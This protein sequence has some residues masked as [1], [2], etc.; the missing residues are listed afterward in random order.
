[1]SKVTF[2]SLVVQNL[3]PFRDRQTMPLSVKGSKPVVLV[4][5]L[6]GSG[7][8][9]LLTCLQVVLYGS[10]ALG[11]IRGSEYEQLIRGL[12]RNDAIG[13][14][15]I[16]LELSVETNGEREIL[17]VT[18]EWSIKRE[19]LQEQLS[20]SRSGQVDFQLT[21]DW[22]DYLDEILPAE[23]L[24]LFLFD[25]EKIEALA[26]PKTLPD[27]LRRATEAFLG[28]GGIDALA[29]NLNAVERRSLLQ[30]RSSSGDY[31]S[32]KAELQTLESGLEEATDKSVI[33]KQS[34]AHAT[35]LLEIARQAYAR[36]AAEAQ[37]SGLAAYEKAAEVRA[38]EHAARKRVGEAEQAV[39][40]AL[41]DPHLPFASLGGLWGSYKALWVSE[42]E[43]HSGHQLYEAIARRDARLLKSIADLIPQTSLNIVSE[44]LASD[45]A[46]IKAS[47]SRPLVLVEAPQ[48]EAI[49][50][51]IEAAKTRYE[52]AQQT[53][54]AA[55]QELEAMER[56]V[57]AIPRGEQLADML[58]EM[59]DKAAVV[60]KA[61]AELESVQQQLAET[62]SSVQHLEARVSASKA[63]MTKEFQGQA[64]DSRA[65]A[66]GQRSREILAL[67]KERL[68]AAKAEWLSSAIT[69]EFSA[70]MRK[71]RLVKTVHV[72]PATYQV[73]ILDT[74]GSEL[75]MARLS[76]GERQLLAIS[77]LSALIRKRKS[78]FPVVVDTP[79]ARLDRTHRS[80]LIKQFFA[81]VSHQVM[82]LSTDEEVEGDVFT[83]MAKHAS[84]TH[85]ITFSDEERC[86]YVSPWTDSTENVAP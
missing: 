32:A 66:A 43:T 69:A 56:Q 9:T 12:Q 28:I 11:G 8:T 51:L 57:A 78:R 29:K 22:E 40:D 5:A 31:E 49:E 24:Q 23:L 47:A 68:L 82:V 85:L 4:K 3:G 75:P 61:E 18:R 7:K 58:A 54:E 84:H 15:C 42:R 25:G 2:L 73:S 52:E 20:V 70:L 53:L 80:S 39:C 27:M 17:K 16:E 44:A 46:Q 10:K 62:Q 33:L 30:A 59:K 37:R 45:A 76:A 67:F 36:F 63:R 83:E 21:Q 19:R 74:T 77:V 71:K 34:E 41:A 6:N 38:A 48:P 79:L 64:L 55:K 86:S 14:P 50:L 13:S 72:D 65:L 1:M 35:N 26:N 81:K 60:S